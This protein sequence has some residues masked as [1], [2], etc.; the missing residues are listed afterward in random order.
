LLLPLVVREKVAAL[1]Y[2]DAGTGAQE[3][4][5]SYALECLARFCSLWLE[6]I[7][8]RKAGIPAV[9]AEP[10]QERTPSHAAAAPAASSS[11]PTVAGPVPA[12]PI[13]QAYVAEPAAS[14][15]STA[16]A[17]EIAPEDEE[18]HRKARRFAKLLVDEIKL[19]NQSKV[20]EGRKNRDI[21]QRLRDDI[22]K[23]RATYDKRYGQTAAAG[24]DYF[25]QELVRTLCDNDPELLGAGISR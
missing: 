20:T 13:S 8:T 16:A 10:A 7:A 15:S 25:H 14:A 17:V 21:Y 18:I 23:S 1:I 6:V 9:L 5:D 24:A 22:D 4:F 19:Y 2:A 3:T 12:P 11:G